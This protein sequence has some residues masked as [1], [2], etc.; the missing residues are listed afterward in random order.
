MA[1]LLKLT[2]IFIGIAASSVV[3]KPQSLVQLSQGNSNF[4]K[5]KIE[6]VGE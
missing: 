2:T 3:E 6:I 4:E 1:N 5:V